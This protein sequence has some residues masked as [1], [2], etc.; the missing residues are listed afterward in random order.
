MSTGKRLSRY[1]RIEKQ[2][3]LPRSRW[4]RNTYFPHLMFLPCEVT[5][6]SIISWSLSTPHF[7]L[8]EHRCSPLLLLGQAW[9]VTGWAN[10]IQGLRIR[11]H[12]HLS[13]KLHPST[14]F[15]ICLS[16][17]LISNSKPKALHVWDLWLTPN[18]QVCHPRR[19]KVEQELPICSPFP[20][21][22]RVGSDCPLSHASW[23]T[24]W[25]LHYWVFLYRKETS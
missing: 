7:L 21:K 5:F 3:A 25:P 24:E 8:G 2:M 20:G 13:Y 14:F 17:S 22:G 1:D 9:P 10:L 6:L 4:Y 15:P 18:L 16:L 23:M 11:K 12:T 19:V